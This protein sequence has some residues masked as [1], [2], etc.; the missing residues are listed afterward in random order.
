[1]LEKIFGKLNKIPSWVS[2][3]ALAVG[4]VVASIPVVLNGE[5]FINELT[6]LLE[7]VAPANTT[8]N[9][10]GGFVYLVAVLDAILS[11]LIIEVCAHFVFQWAVNNRYTNRGKQYYVTAVRYAFALINLVIGLYDIVGVYVSHVVYSYVGVAFLFV[12]R[13]AVV[14]FVY[15]GI[16]K[17]CIN[18]KFVFNCYNRLYLIYFM[19]NAALNLLELFTN[20]LSTEIDVGYAIY[21]G[22]MV[23]I[24]A[25]SA[26]ALYLTVFKKLKKEQEEARKIVIIPPVGGGDNS[27][28][29]KGFGL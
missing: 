14:T 26:L 28:I 20:V 13:T 29:F 27:E 4:V 7:N 2:I 25:L 23:A 10:S 15:L 6:A 17:E 9:V 16:R 18:D 12:L 3:V 5:G 22:V 11:Y 19:Y 8:P 24:V 21:S 1:M